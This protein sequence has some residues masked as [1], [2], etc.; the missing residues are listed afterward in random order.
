MRVDR[1]QIPASYVRT[2]LLSRLGFVQIQSTI[3]GIT[4]H[5]YPTDI[6]KL[7]V[8]I[9]EVSDALKHEWFACDEK[10]ALAGDASEF[11]SKL[12]SAAKT[13][14]EAL[15]EGVITEQ[16]LIDANKALDADD[17]SLDRDILAR[18]TTKGLD[19]D[20]DPLFPDLEQ[21]YDLLAQSQRLNE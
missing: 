8:P 10:M 16:Q 15:I 1:D 20:G 13:I 14:V 4:A 2:Y 5:S 9:P 11:A 7:D 6:K 18:L 21:L 17:A 12:T 3:R 19:G